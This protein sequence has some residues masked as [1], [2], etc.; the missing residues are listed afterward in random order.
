[1][2]LNR[3]LAQMGIRV[4]LSLGTLAFMVSSAFAATPQA[5]NLGPEDQSKQISVT[6]WLNM[7]NKA[8][9]DTM[10]QQMYD[11]SSPNYHKFLTLKEF[12]EGI[13]SSI[14]AHGKGSRH[15]PRF[16]CLLQHESH[17]D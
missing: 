6:V 2:P 17:L 15:G 16:P 3:R 11:K 13:Q 8:A 12:T 10:V 1:M 9:L 14:R 5:T 7:H 4:S